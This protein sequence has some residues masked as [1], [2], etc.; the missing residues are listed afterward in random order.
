[1]YGKEAVMEFVKKQLRRLQLMD[2]PYS[3]NKISL[4]NE[5]FITS[6]NSEKMIALNFYNLGIFEAGLRQEH[7]AKLV[8]FLIAYLVKAKSLHF[9]E[10]VFEDLYEEF[11]LYLNEGKFVY[12]TI[13]LIHRLDTKNQVV[14]FPDFCIR[15]VD[16]ENIEYFYNNLE[17]YYNNFSLRHIQNNHLPNAI[18]MLEQKQVLD[19]SAKRKPIREQIEK[20]GQSVVLYNGVTEHISFSPVITFSYF[21]NNGM[22]KEFDYIYSVKNERLQGFVRMDDPAS[23]VSYFQNI[24]LLKNKFI[25]LDRL[26]SAHNKADMEDKFIDLMIALESMFPSITS[27][28]TFRI[29]LYTATLLDRS[30]DTYKTVKDLYKTRSNLVHGSSKLSREQ[31]AK[32]LD[33]LDG[34]VRKVIVQALKYHEMGF[35]LG[36]MEEDIVKVL[37]PN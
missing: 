22:I 26:A 13:A 1:M 32:Q 14:S 25:A 19:D 35:G 4:D 24:T 15:P 11:L 7:D 23:L 12:R 6:I 29:A 34:I 31:L 30:Q 18:A 10:L 3:T 33:E 21:D 8:K 20:L 9:I 5:G 36:K 16:K 2:L 28:V 37:L 27:E 17:E